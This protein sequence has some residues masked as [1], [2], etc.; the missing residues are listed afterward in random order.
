MPNQLSPRPCAAFYSDERVGGE[1]SVGPPSRS[2]PDG[3]RASQKN[4]RISLNERKPMVPN[5]KVSGQ[6]M[7]AEVRLNT[8]SEPSDTTI[9]GMLLI[10]STGMR[11]SV[12]NSV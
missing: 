7:T 8:R 6:L 3:F 10:K 9:F 2:A 4:E 12:P 1:G 11:K 5:F